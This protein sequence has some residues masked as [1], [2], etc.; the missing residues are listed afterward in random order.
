MRF[1]VSMFP[2][3]GYFLRLFATILITDEHKHVFY[4]KVTFIISHASIWPRDYKD[5]KSNKTIFLFTVTRCASNLSFFK[6][7]FLDLLV[8]T[9]LY[10]KVL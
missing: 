4:E 8:N 6:T 10:R 2:D 1:F 9:R 7:S 5:K 3:L